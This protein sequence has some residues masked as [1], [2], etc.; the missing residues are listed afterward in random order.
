[1]NCGHGPGILASLIAPLGFIFLFTEPRF[2]FAVYASHDL[3]TIGVML[4]VGV[5]V[6]LSLASVVPP[7]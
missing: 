3:I 4:A 7:R 2:S 6:D 5:V 1:M